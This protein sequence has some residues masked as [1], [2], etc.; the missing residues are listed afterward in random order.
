M[1][2]II[3][4]NKIRIYTGP[5]P[6]QYY[7]ILVEE[8]G[9]SRGSQAETV[10]GAKTF[11]GNNTYQGSNT[12]SGTETF[13]GPVT[14]GA[15]SGQILT[16][17]KTL[18]AAEIVGVAAGDIGHADGA[19]LVAAPGAGKAIQFISAI[20][21]YDFLTAAYTGGAD[22]SAIIYPGFNAVSG[23]ITDSEL[24][25]SAGDE[26]ISLLALSAAGIPM[27]TNV[28]LN[29][30]GTAFTNPGTAAGVLRCTINYR[31]ITTGL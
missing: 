21:I 13:N 6:N 25:T 15:D 31:I 10:T 2:E 12:H 1:A 11:Q 30:K 16:A 22:D 28:G 18:T 27:V 23:V 9:I 8:S 24:I 3:N 17:T 19:I 29:L 7:D 26:M 5:N 4:G 14:M 20:L